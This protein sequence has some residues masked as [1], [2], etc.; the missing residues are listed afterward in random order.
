MGA[1]DEGP[2]LAAAHLATGKPFAEAQYDMDPGFRKLFALQ[3]NVLTVY[4]NQPQAENLLE[5]GEAS[6]MSG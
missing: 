4:T 2:P 3:P 6:I 1:R 5:T